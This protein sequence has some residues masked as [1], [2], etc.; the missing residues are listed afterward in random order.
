[1]EALCTDTGAAAITNDGVS[2]WQ[3][4]GLSNRSILILTNNGLRLNH[5]MMEEKHFSH[6][7]ISKFCHFFRQN[8]HADV[9]NKA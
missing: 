8:C 5:S 6:F 4:G 1:M 3:V 7:M 2:T 9:F